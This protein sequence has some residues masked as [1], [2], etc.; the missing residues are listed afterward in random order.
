MEDG[1]VFSRSR[2]DL[3]LRTC[4]FRDSR[5]RLDTPHVKDDLV[6]L[7]C[8]EID[9]DTKPTPTFILVIYEMRGR[10]WLP[11]IGK[12]SLDI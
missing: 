5:V 3:A 6:L 11:Q 9:T 1:V 10:D 12:G 7:I 4:S 2:L 8:T